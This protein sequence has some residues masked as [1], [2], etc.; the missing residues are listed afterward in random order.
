MRI[1]RIS[2]REKHLELKYGKIKKKPAEKRKERDLYISR[3]NPG[4]SPRLTLFM[5]RTLTTKSGSAC[6][7][8]RNARKKAR[9]AERERFSHDDRN[10]CE[11]TD[12]LFCLR[13]IFSRRWC[14]AHV[15]GIIF[16]LF[17]YFIY[18]TYIYIC[19]MLIKKKYIT[20]PWN[21]WKIYVFSFA[22]PC[23]VVLEVLIY[24]FSFV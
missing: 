17:F 16:F 21:I 8:C 18:F 2:S 4:T 7:K 11:E 10:I 1:E 14:F 12:K 19:Q 15:C 6:A 13:Y 5:K 9:R 22:M 24:D 20:I 3:K 23:G